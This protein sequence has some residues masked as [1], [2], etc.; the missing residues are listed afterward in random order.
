M[1]GP[2]HYAEAERLLAMF[3]EITDAA[4]RDRM[5]ETT[6][7]RALEIL[8]AR[9]QVHATLALAAATVATKAFGP[10]ELWGG[11]TFEAGP[12]WQQVTE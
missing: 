1:N 8:F 4:I 5:S 3:D 2:S 9:A 10:Q 12:E 7:T 11:H 6:T